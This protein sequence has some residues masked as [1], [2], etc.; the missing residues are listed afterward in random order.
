MSSKLTEL[1]DSSP[2]APP[3][4]VL[5]G[6]DILSWWASPWSMASYGHFDPG[7]TYDG[8]K[9]VEVHDPACTEFLAKGKDCFQNFNPKSSKCHFC[10]VGKKPCQCPGSVASN[11][12][13]H[14]WSKKNGPFGKEF[15]VSEGLT[16]DAISGYS[17]LTGSRQ[18]DVARWTNFGG[19]IPV[20]GRPIYS[21]LE[22]PISRINTEGVVKR[23]IRITDS[24]S[25]PD[26]EGSDELDGEEVEVVNNP[27]G[28]QP[29]TSPSQPPAKIFQSHLIPSNPR[30]FQPTLA[31][32][33]TS[34][35]PASPSSSH[36]R[37]AINIAVRPSP[38]QQSRASPI[39][40]S[41]QLKPEAS[42]SRRRGEL[43]PLPFPAAQV[44]QQRDCWPI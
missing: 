41:Q 34:L 9:A 11:F 29:S 40:T 26:A 4:S 20:S 27:V 19:S 38:I 3:P 32:I 15:P 23:I 7:Q 35:P 21:S 28:H 14:L 37:P 18:R 17:D 31:A 5:C 6:S 22:V 39:V 43:S 13:R 10:F 33:P 36:S 25:D 8:Y 2:S 44:F 16:P 30:D 24:P 12:R 1:T 42:S